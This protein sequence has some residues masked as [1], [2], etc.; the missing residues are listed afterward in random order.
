MVADLDRRTGI[1]VQAGVWNL[2]P[3]WYQVAFLALLV[4]VSAVGGRLVRR[5]RGE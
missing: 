2:M 3:V 4:P 1:A 5:E